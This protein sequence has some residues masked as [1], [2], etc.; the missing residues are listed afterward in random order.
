VRS[1][2]AGDAPLDANPLVLPATPAAPCRI[3]ARSARES[4]ATSSCRRCCRAAPHRPAAGL[5]G[6]PPAAALP[7]AGVDDDLHP[8]RSVIARVPKA[9]LGTLRKRR[10]R[11]EIGAHQIV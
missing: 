3:A 10:I 8:I 1:P 11:L 2:R 5:P 9:A 6:A 4:P 7:E